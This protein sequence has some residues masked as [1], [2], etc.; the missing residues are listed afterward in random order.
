MH[1]I[2]EIPSASRR[3]QGLMTHAAQTGSAGV[4]PGFRL[5]TVAT[6][7]YVPHNLEE[8]LLIKVEI[9]QGEKRHFSI[10]KYSYDGE[11]RSPR[12]VN[13]RER[14]LTLND[15]ITDEPKPWPGKI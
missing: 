10:I 3:L 11:V 7:E 1:S 9:R 2:K 13:C 4:K 15:L 5:V 12:A 8:P 14:I 6:V